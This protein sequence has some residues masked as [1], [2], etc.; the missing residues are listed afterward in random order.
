ME[1][2]NIL[3][4]KSFMELPFDIY[5]IIIKY[6]DDERLIL[7]SLK[8]YFFM[9]S[10]LRKKLKL[11]PE[12]K[13]PEKV[14]S[15]DTTLNIQLGNNMLFSMFS[16]FFTP[17]KKNVPE[18]FLD[19]F[20]RIV[21]KNGTLNQR[22]LLWKKLKLK[23][24]DYKHIHH[25]TRR[26]AS[27]LPYSTSKI[28]ESLVGKSIKQCNHKKTFEE[29]LEKIPK[30]YRYK[31]WSHFFK[32]IPNTEDKQTFPDM[33]LLNTITLSI[34][35]S[36]RK[37]LVI[38][39]K[40]IMICFQF[41]MTIVLFYLLE[42]HS[43]FIFEIG[44]RDTRN[45]LVDLYIYNS[46]DYNYLDLFTNEKIFTLVRKKHLKYAIKNSSFEF[47]LQLLKLQNKFSD[48][49]KVILEL[50][51]EIHPKNNKQFEFFNIY[52]ESRIM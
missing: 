33:Y 32:I 4:E 51:K 22:L 6:I 37:E 21:G 44:S 43:H 34:L 13:G 49:N 28:Y 17:L 46:L 2:G 38:D 30:L 5:S 19:K 40:F 7:L 52:K 9:E 3:D 20:H 29:S 39:E 47:L 12:E 11:D 50:E 41:K 25:Y 8:D 26:D 1:I 31:L 15:V 18:S 27:L 48:F 14:L 10:L 24:T 23:F 16:N 45:E 42:N 35:H 36:F